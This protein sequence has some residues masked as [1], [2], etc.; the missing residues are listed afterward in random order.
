MLHGIEAGSEGCEFLWMFP[1]RRWKDS[2]P[3]VNVDLQVEIPWLEFD[4]SESVSPLSSGSLGMVLLASK[5]VH[6]SIFAFA[7]SRIV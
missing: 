2:R 4:A 3:E 7:P 5:N 1:A 6:I